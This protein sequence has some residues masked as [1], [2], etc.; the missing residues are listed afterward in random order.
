MRI[1]P[2]E[3]KVYF[4]GASALAFAPQQKGNVMTYW[5]EKMLAEER[6]LPD[7]HTEAGRIAHREFYVLHN[8]GPVVYD[9]KGKAWAPYHRTREEAEMVFDRWHDFI[10]SGKSRGV[11]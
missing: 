11:S 9:S 4:I 1:T 5:I 3:T 10:I 7:V 8:V 2:V 6:A